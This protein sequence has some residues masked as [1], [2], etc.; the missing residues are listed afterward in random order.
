[1]LRS[2]NL[3]ELA[4]VFVLC[5]T[6]T[7]LR[8]FRLDYLSLWGDELETAVA[9]G[10]TTGMIVAYRRPIMLQYLIFHWFLPHVGQ[11]DWWLRFPTALC[12]SLSLPVMY[13]LA[14]RHLDRATAFLAT[15]L[16]AANYAHLVQSQNARYYGFMGLVTLLSLLV[17]FELMR[18]FRWWLLPAFLLVHVLNVL[19]HVVAFFVFAAEGLCWAMVAL[20][21]IRAHRN[22]WRKRLLLAGAGLCVVGAVGLFLLGNVVR[23]FIPL[24]SQ[25][26]LPE[27]AARNVRLFLTSTAD[28]LGLVLRWKY[29]AVALFV[30]SLVAL[31]KKS[32]EIFLLTVL[33]YCVT[34]VGLLRGKWIWKDLPTRYIFYCQ[35]LLLISVSTLFV[36]LGRFV[37]RRIP[38]GREAVKYRV[39]FVILAVGVMAWGADNVR[40]FLHRQPEEDWRAAAEYVQ[41]HSARGDYLLIGRTS[42]FASDFFRW[43]ARNPQFHIFSLTAEADKRPTVERVYAVLAAAGQT[44]RVWLFS[45]YDRLFREEADVAPM[46]DTL[47][48]RVARFGQYPVLYRSAEK[49]MFHVPQIWGWDLPVAKELQRGGSPQV[50]R[51]LTVEEDGDYV[52][53]VRTTSGVAVERLLADGVTV[54]SLA[55][56]SGEPRLARPK[57]AAGNHTVGVVFHQVQ[58]GSDTAPMLS[59]RVG[60]MYVPA[61]DET[62]TRIRATPERASLLAL[63]AYAVSARQIRPGE[64]FQQRVY[65]KFQDRTYLQPRF[66]SVLYNSS[67]GRFQI[68]NTLTRSKILLGED[69]W[70]VMEHNYEARIP[71][72]APP[73]HY[74]IKCSF[75]PY[76]TRINAYLPRVVRIE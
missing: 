70:Y 21:R 15:F 10:W 14:R 58:S 63:W 5:A 69:G 9:S 59:I 50:T 71:A 25:D 72:G 44:R 67:N 38:W 37:A 53:V 68:L 40:R 52:V 56:S 45:V 4:A 65:W 8:F 51:A 57:W 61:P 64:T 11:N 35:P 74:T 42:M 66:K 62:V 29:V 6:G 36:T 48:T 18:R 28:F 73:E 24:V 49:E 47:F 27:M 39:V 23:Q 34:L 43:Y 12:G 17:L 75:L 13:I 3:Y 20:W 41:S 2:I 55:A 76:E 22:D 60:R 54:L 7:F 33:L 19:N 32:R 26:E 30:L 16:L 46:L 31:F 1:L